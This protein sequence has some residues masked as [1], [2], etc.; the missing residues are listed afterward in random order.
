M[1]PKRKANN[2]K[3]RRTKADQPGTATTPTASPSKPNSANH[4]TQSTPNQQN[5]SSPATPIHPTPN[6]SSQSDHHL[7]KHSADSDR[8]SK[9]SSAATT[10]GSQKSLSDHLPAKSNDLPSSVKSTASNVDSAALA[11]RSANLP[12]SN[13]NGKTDHH[14]SNPAN[15]TGRPN[16]STTE[17]NS[18]QASAA[19]RVQDSGGRDAENR[20]DPA[21]GSKTDTKKT[22]QASQ[23][24]STNN[25]SEDSRPPSKQHQSLEDPAPVKVV[26][27]DPAKNSQNGM[28][29]KES[30]KNKSDQH[31]E[32]ETASPVKSSSENDPAKSLPSSAKKPAKHVKFTNATLADDQSSSDTSRPTHENH[33]KQ[34]RAETAEEAAELHTKPKSIRREMSGA[35]DQFDFDAQ[36][37]MYAGP[38]GGMVKKV[39]HRRPVNGN[40][41]PTE[42]QRA[43]DEPVHEPSSDRSSAAS[44][45]E[46]RA[47][48]QDTIGFQHAQR[49][50]QSIVEIQHLNAHPDELDPDL[51]Q[52]YLSY[53]DQDQDGLLDPLD[54]WRAFRRLGFGLLWAVA[55]TFTLHLLISPFIGM[56]SWF[57][58]DVLGRCQLPLGHHLSGSSRSSINIDPHDISNI[59][60]DHPSG[61][62]GPSALWKKTQEHMGAA[63][64][65]DPVGWIKFVI[66]WLIAISLTWPSD[67]S[68]KHDLINGVYNGE[69]LFLVAQGVSS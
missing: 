4:S 38:G 52:I 65:T 68:V 16:K 3:K 11:E 22:Q 44:A 56:G 15:E 8:S 46:S 63:E 18:K 39:C 57:M 45:E 42:D 58:P 69:L 64:M 7:H 40:S 1:A 43:S 24:A 67:L 55:A 5:H 14:H 19:H 60:K 47:R 10:A 29:P 66:G 62:V 25:H 59:D 23:K 20:P 34:G 53:F 2:T 49:C 13:S 12:Q 17:Q 61:K 31:K 26:A 50:L 41:H 9:P 6:G 51:L 37:R 33:R 21:V 28:I 27:S 48:S 30:V 32:S 35:A 36:Q 54:T